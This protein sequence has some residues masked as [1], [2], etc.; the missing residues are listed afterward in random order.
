MSN[1]INNNMINYDTCIDFIDRTEKILEKFSYTIYEKDSNN[2]P[3]P[4]NIKLETRKYLKETNKMNI[5]HYRCHIHVIA[6]KNHKNTVNGT[7]LEISFTLSHRFKA[8]KGANKHSHIYLSIK[9][10]DLSNKIILDGYKK[11]GNCPKKILEDTN[12]DELSNFLIYENFMK[13]YDNDFDF[14]EQPINEKDLYNKSL[15]VSNIKFNKTL[16]KS[17]FMLRDNLFWSK[18]IK[19]STTQLFDLLDNIFKYKSTNKSDIQSLIFPN[20]IKNN[21]NDAQLKNFIDNIKK[22][23][24][25][26]EINNMI[27]FNKLKNYI[28]TRDKVMDFNNNFLNMIHEI[29]RIYNDY[30]CDYQLA[31][32]IE[33]ITDIE[34]KKILASEENNYNNLLKVLIIYVIDDYIAVNKSKKL[35]YKNKSMIY[36]CDIIKKI[37]TS[38]YDVK[39][40]SILNKNNNELSNRYKIITNHLDNIRDKLFICDFLDGELN[41]INTFINT[42]ETYQID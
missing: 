41:K 7:N 31:K 15:D 22:N 16:K 2:I 34:N 36:Y 25:P 13:M 10:D 24:F 6:D 3:Y 40:K 21:I 5:H 28:D 12:A 8:E 29:I 20:K 1:I 35:S 23:H 14:I 9:Y 38:I 17:F 11:K 4:K 42:L 27:K 18:L 26:D 39:E 30:F 33:K 32:K 19:Y 37:I